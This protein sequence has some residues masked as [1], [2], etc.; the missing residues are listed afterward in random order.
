[1]IKWLALLP[2]PLL[3]HEFCLYEP[4]RAVEENLE[5]DLGCEVVIST[6]GRIQNFRGLSPEGKILFYKDVEQYLA[7]CVKTLDLTW[8]P[9][10]ERENGDPLEGI[11]FY[12]VTTTKPDG[13]TVIDYPEQPSFSIKT[14]QKGTYTFSVQAV[15]FDDKPSKMTEP[16]YFDM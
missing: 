7:E 15:D 12:S 2:L 1:M 10:T 6:T 14:T 5:R 4:Y 16:I 11:Q 9:P 3:A 8:T 13:E